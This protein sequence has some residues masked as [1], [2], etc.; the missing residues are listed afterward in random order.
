[1]KKK[2]V[3]LQASVVLPT[4]TDPPAVSKVVRCTFSS[5]GANILRLSDVARSV[6]LLDAFQ[7]CPIGNFHM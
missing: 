7:G 1:V 4:Q 3:K 6:P 2:G 5:D